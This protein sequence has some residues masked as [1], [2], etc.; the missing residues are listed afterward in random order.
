[1]I[2]RE[3][4][5]AETF[6]CFLLLVGQTELGPMMHRG[7]IVDDVEEERDYGDDSNTVAVDDK[8]DAEEDERTRTIELEI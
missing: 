6:V 5:R 8:S 3:R 2:E 7:E 1:M 4:E